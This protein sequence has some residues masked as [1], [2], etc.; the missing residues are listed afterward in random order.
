M[1]RIRAPERDNAQEI[2][3]QHNGEITNREIANQLNIDEKKVAVWKQRDNWDKDSKK[4]NVVQQKKDNKKS[5]VQQNKSNNKKSTKK[6]TTDTISIEVKEVMENEELTDKQKLFCIYYSKCFNQTKAYLKAYN[7][8][9]ITANS[10][11]SKLMVNARI[12]AMINKLTEVTMDKAALTRGLIQKY[13]DIAFSDIG[14]YVEF[15][16]RQIP[17]WTKN[18]DGVDI[19]IINPDTGEQMIKEYSYVDLK[20]SVGVDTS[21]I[22]E[23]SEGK[24]GIKFK[25]ADKM[26]A[27]DFLNK[28]CNLLNDEEKTKLELENKRLQNEK[29]KEEIKKIKGEEDEVVQDDG[30]MTALNGKT[31][32]VWNE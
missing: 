5:V 17:Q 4:N 23:V 12:K 1:A 9:Y 10:N 13:I 19:P 25:L 24:D 2:Y 20:N 6:D 30:F 32:E 14:E 15:G 3:I 27:M 26:K 22:S 11:A 16:V 28:H 31:V 8:D 7:C 29:S 18:S 21:I